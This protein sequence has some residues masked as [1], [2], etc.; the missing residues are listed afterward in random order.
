MKGK[1][2]CL[3]G[4]FVE[5]Y[6]YFDF[7]WLFS[8]DGTVRAFDIA[9]F[10]AERL[11]GDGEAAAALFSDN[12]L[13]DQPFKIRTKASAT[14]LL[15]KGGA[16]EVSAK[17][18]DRYSYIFENEL[19]FRSLLDVRFYYGRAYVGTD[20]NIV[21]LFARD[22]ADLQEL[23]R[24]S[25]RQAS[26]G[27]RSV[28][29][30]PARAFRCRFG[31]VGAACGRG[32]GLIGVGADT[33]DRDW[34]VKFKQFAETS[35]GLALN[36]HAVTNLAS[37]NRIQFFKATLSEI[38][39]ERP[40]SFDEPEED[41]RRHIISVSDAAFLPQAERVNAVTA[42]EETS[43]I[44]LFNRTLW[45]FDANGRQERSTFV[46]SNLEI[47]EINRGPARKGPPGRVLSMSSMQA[48]VLA[49]TDDAVF[50]YSGRH[51]IPLVEEAVYSVR[52]YQNSKRYQRIATAVTRDRV[53]VIAI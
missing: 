34:T 41:W 30:L 23:K 39:T 45:R 46:N 11:N 42:S 43:G 29:D 24:G 44:F 15:E 19:K 50:L 5:A 53:E 40:V 33:S 17:D 16:Y 9:S 8:K 12:R 32:G 31:A 14:E 1:R 21:Q 26:L 47:D 52:G 20:T 35:F 28:S 3:Y 10:C 36:G 51:W 18:V 38:T 37:R 7:L 4:R 13:L 22:R 48:G 49:E 25:S 2:L 27:G 6:L